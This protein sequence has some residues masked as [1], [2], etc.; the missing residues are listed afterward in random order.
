M[1]SR[2]IFVF[3]WICVA[4]GVLFI[5]RP[6]LYATVQQPSDE[7]RAREI[8]LKYG[9]N[10]AS[11]LALEK[12]KSLYFGEHTEGVIAYGVV[13]NCLIVQADPICADEDFIPFLS[14]FNMF[15]RENDYHLLFMSTSDKYLEEYKK[16]GFVHVKCGEEA[17][18]DLSTY[19]LAGGKMA[20]LRPEINHAVKKGVTVAEYKPLEQKDVEIE[21]GIAAVTDDWLGGKKS[22]QLCFS[23]GDVNLDHPMD[24]RYFYA[25]DESGRIVAFNVFLPFEGK[26][27]WM[28][29]VTRRSHDAPRGSTEKITFDAFMQFKEE[30]CLWG[31]MGVS[32]L[33]NIEGEENEKTTIGRILK[34]V[35][36]KGNRFYGF[37]SLHLAKE[38]YSPSQWIPSYFVY[39]KKAI[40]IDMGIAIVKLQNPGGFADFFT[41]FFTKTVL[42]KD[43]KKTKTDNKN[44]AKEQN[45]DKVKADVQ[46]K[47]EKSEQV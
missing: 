30:G 14:E 1:Y 8:V 39:S 24:R 31:S 23:V 45:T 7:K 2:F 36:E 22:S 41:S 13:D 17:R 40:N 3:F 15:C 25:K 35:Y 26:K 10:S 28:A 12:D 19:Q 6:V 38:K 43:K 21:R 42:K 34:L 16:M 37:K 20:R 46:N 44:P 11:Y 33:A 32:P 27:G 9:Q 18:I 4:V 5:L 29:D 47:T